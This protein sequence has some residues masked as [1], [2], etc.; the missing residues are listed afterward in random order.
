M[1]PGVRYERTT[2]TA[3]DKRAAKAPRARTGDRG[4]RKSQA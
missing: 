3:S 4:K 1:F 2:E